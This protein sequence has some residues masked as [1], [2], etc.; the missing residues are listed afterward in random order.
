MLMMRTVF[1]SRFTDGIFSKNTNT[2]DETISNPNYEQ[3]LIDL[4][5]NCNVKRSNYLGL[6][7]F[8]SCW[9]PLEVE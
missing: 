5:L 2:R 9:K 7:I 1:D 4:Q 6:D 3:F 8:F